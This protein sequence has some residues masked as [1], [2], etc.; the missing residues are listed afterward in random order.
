M[1]KF[2]FPFVQAFLHSSLVHYTHLY[3]SRLTWTGFCAQEP[4]PPRHLHLAASTPG[5]A[6]QDHQPAPRYDR[7][8]RRCARLRGGL[9]G[10]VCGSTT[11]QRGE[12][13][14]VSAGTC[15]HGQ[16]AMVL[17]EKTEK[18][19]RRSILKSRWQKGGEITHGTKQPPT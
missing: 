8:R 18:N 19:G 13:C 10:P 4:Q 16:T 2:F 1:N 7:S 3:A 6:A 12:L 5:P 14:H 17:K 9:P 15:K 11:A